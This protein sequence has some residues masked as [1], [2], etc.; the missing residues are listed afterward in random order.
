MNPETITP[1]QVEEIIERICTD[2]ASVATAC[3]G[4]C[5]P[6]TFWRKLRAD[7][8]LVAA[9]EKAREIRA[10]A[11][12]ESIDSVLGALSASKIDAQQARV[13]VDAIK[14]QCGI[15]RPKRYGDKLATTISGPDGGAVQVKMELDAAKESLAARIDSIAARLTESGDTGG[16]PR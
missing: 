3:D 1:E 4:I 2:K 11:R 16:N 9:Y 10:D 6:R 8:E 13:M 15:E 7:P 14:W 12:F 5:A